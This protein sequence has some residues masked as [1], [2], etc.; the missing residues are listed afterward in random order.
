MNSARGH[1]R[2][3]VRCAHA[4]T[5]LP[6][7]PPAT[8]AA[9]AH[10]ASAADPSC[11]GWVH[12]AAVRLGC[13]RARPRESLSSTAGAPDLR[14]EVRAQPQPPLGPCC[15]C[16][17]LAPSLRPPRLT[18]FSHPSPGLTLPGMNCAGCSAQAPTR[19]RRA[20][21]TGR[22]SGRCTRARPRASQSSTARASPSRRRTCRPTLRVYIIL[23]CS[24]SAARATRAA[25]RPWA[26][27]APAAPSTRAAAA[28]A[29][30]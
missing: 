22:G 1:G 16:A 11:A 4:A 15:S 7:C 12:V 25:P 28:S 23:P 26:W 10:G 13:T 27:T 21:G 3:G 18:S 6:R 29:P 20:A 17:A 24:P 9:A 14:R 8:S 19:A 5:Q 2:C 30:V